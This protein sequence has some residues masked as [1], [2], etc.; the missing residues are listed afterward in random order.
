MLMY[1][2]NLSR[3]LASLMSLPELLIVLKISP[4]DEVCREVCIWEAKR[5]RL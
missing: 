4:E 1:E 5:G 2:M 3:I